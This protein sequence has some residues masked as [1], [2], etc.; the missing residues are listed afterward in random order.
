MI[1]LIITTSI[2]DTRFEHKQNPEVRKQQYLECIRAALDN[3]P[4]CI[5]PVIVEN[6]GERQTFLDDFGIPVI[7]TTNNKTQE[8]HKG[9]NELMDIHDVIDRLNM[10]DH[11]T[12]IK[13]TGRYKILNDTFFKLVLENQSYD[14][15]VKFFNVV[16]VKYMHNDCALGLYAMKVEHLKKFK[17]SQFSKSAEVDFS[18]YCRSLNVLECMDL[19]LLYRRWCGPDLIV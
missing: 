17:Y 12:V 16:T 13:M 11:D 15:I 1:Y 9:V 6:N 8:H 5:S 3:L 4:T 2:I 18:E 7:Y 19:G 14:C 10:S